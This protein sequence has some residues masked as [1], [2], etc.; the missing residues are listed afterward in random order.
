MPECDPGVQGEMGWMGVFSWERRADRCWWNRSDMRV[1]RGVL[2]GTV[3]VG[4]VCGVAVGQ[5]EA[6]APPVKLYKV[7][8]D[9][10]GKDTHSNTQ[11]N[12]EYVALKN[13]GRRAVKL[14]GWT[15]ADTKRHVYK[16]KVFTLKP[17][18]VVYVHTGKG[19]DTSVNVFQNRAWYVWNNTADTVTLR[20]SAGTKIDTCRWTRNGKG[21]IYC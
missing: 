12:R 20:N 7:V 11:L 17:G 16:F 1:L 2:A 3:A 10:S 21:Y 4:A 19:H 15:V 13:T 8:Y 18:K 14:T 6:A 5:A 9:P